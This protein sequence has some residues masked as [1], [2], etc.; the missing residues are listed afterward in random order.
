MKFEFKLPDVG[1]GIHEAELLSWSVKPGDR[2]REGQDIAVLNTD[3][4]TVDLPSPRS[5]TIV[6]LHGKPGDIITVST[7]LVVI[8]VDEAHA[9]PS[10]A[11]AVVPRPMPA[12]EPERPAAV[13][14]A[15]GPSVR[16]LARQKDVDLERLVGSGPRGRILLADV[17]AA[18]G[19]AAGGSPR[20][21]EPAAGRDQPARTEVAVP[22]AVAA[23]A[24]GMR[25]QRLS[26]ARLVSARNLH[27][28][29]RRTVTTTTT[30]EVGG[31]GLRH[32]MAALAPE[33]QERQMKLSPL[34]VI[35]KCVA[36]ALMRH[37]RF[38]ATV[39][40][41]TQEIVFRDG[42]DLGIAVA[43]PDRLVVPVVR[44]V[45]Q[46]LLFDLVRQIDDYSER[47]RAGQL[48]VAELSGGSFTLSSTGGM[49]RVTVLSTRP[50][51]NPPQT[52]TLWVSR[53]ND[54]PRVIDG[55]LS[56]GPMLTCSLSFDHR[57]IDGAEAVR[58]VNDLGDYLEH[59]ERALG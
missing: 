11:P 49:E 12:G 27:D 34:H 18:V 1:E 23:P 46:R 10:A 33:A 26:G 43:A 42:V 21:A 16:R 38:N 56:A 40:E 8:D 41:E 15:A 5:G 39:D 50:I 47:A 19:A 3:K 51:I 44:G 36:A 30:F 20:T 7:V 14:V 22:P 31:D 53:I 6:S 35:A 32:L 25:R 29:V 52:A 59:P 55:Q 13:P 58:F 24:G 48:K 54:R 9:V 17:E 4:V 2:V 28:S 57:Y 37:E 45:Q